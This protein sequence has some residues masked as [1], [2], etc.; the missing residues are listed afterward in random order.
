MLKTRFYCNIF[1]EVKRMKKERK[2]LVGVLLVLLLLSVCIPQK[3]YAADYVGEISIVSDGSTKEAIWGVHSFLIYKNLTDKDQYVA[4][5]TVKPGSSIT[6]GTYGN[7]N[8]GKGVYINLEAYYASKY[9]AYS[10]R[11]SLSKKITKKGLDKFKKAIDDN[12]KWTDTKNCAWFATTVWNKVVSEKYEV[13]AGKIA[14]PA[15][16]SKNIKKKKN[17]KSKIALP[18][19][20]TTYRYKNKKATKCSASSKKNSWNSSWTD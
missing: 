6:I 10:S 2:V 3:V 14:T 17:Y 18:K 5:T 16:L 12:N 11:V 7:Q 19:V 8:S 13:S 1:T 15:T 4:N 20:N 9:G